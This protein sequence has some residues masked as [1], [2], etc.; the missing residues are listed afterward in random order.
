MFGA[1]LPRD[2]ALQEHG[3]PRFVYRA[4]EY[5]LQYGLGTEGLFR[6]AASVA[7][8]RQLC[9]AYNNGEDP[10]LSVRS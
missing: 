7:Q 2:P 10:D 9:A 6:V 8:V 4:V 1:P 5:L 3:V